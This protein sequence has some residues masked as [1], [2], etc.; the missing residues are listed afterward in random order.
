MDRQD[1]LP[2]SGWRT[3]GNAREPDG[4]APN[5]DHSVPDPRA[6]TKLYDSDAIVCETVGEIPFP[7]TQ[8]VDVHGL[9]AGFVPFL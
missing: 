8:P 5:T 3:K 9:V 7:V 6:L 4:K 2:S 1:K